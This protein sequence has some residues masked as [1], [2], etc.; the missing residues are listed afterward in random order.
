MLFGI[1]SRLGIGMRGST[2][3]E[4]EQIPMTV[5]RSCG[6]DGDMN[7]K[8]STSRAREIQENEEPNLTKQKKHQGRLI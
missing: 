3:T 8:P 2:I 7:P 4:G 6:Q 1:L 5:V